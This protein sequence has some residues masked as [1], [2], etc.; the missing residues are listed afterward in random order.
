MNQKSNTF[1]QIRIADKTAVRNGAA[2]RRAMSAG[3]PPP[4]A[5]SDAEIDADA[6][7]RSF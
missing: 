5:S 1:K 7:P 2:S 3:Q 6:R 4:S